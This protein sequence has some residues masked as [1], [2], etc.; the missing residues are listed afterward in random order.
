MHVKE[1][2]NQT[3]I[4]FAFVRVYLQDIGAS[5]LNPKFLRNRRPVERRMNNS[6][7]AGVSCSSQGQQPR[8]SCVSWIT[9]HAT[10]WFVTIYRRPSACLSNSVRFEDALR[11]VLHRRWLQRRKI[12]RGMAG[13]SPRRQ[14]VVCVRSISSFR[15]WMGFADR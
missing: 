5:P 8:F 7:V 1:E 12:K 14:P 6:R 9:G 4:S 11:T 15:G 13:G 3:N 2:F 10:S